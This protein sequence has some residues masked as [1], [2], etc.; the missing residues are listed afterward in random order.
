MSKLEELTATHHCG[1]WCCH[2]Y[3]IPPNVTMDDKLIQTDSVALLCFSS[4]PSS[5]LAPENKGLRRELGMGK[6]SSRHSSG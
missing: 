5:P 3:F 4:L 1:I 6:V 2:A